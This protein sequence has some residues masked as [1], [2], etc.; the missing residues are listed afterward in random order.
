MEKIK[1][2]AM[3]ILMV[4]ISTVAFAQTEQVSGTVTLLSSISILILDALPV[5]VA[6]V[7][8]SR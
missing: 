3:S 1:T 7:R 2:L 6:A 8:F 4:L 5:S